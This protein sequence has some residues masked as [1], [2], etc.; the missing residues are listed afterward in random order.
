[1]A[2]VNYS[3]PKGSLFPSGT[4][5]VTSTAVDLS[6]N[7]ATCIFDVVLT[8][9]TELLPGLPSYQVISNT[10]PKNFLFYNITYSQNSHLMVRFT[11]YSKAMRALISLQ[12]VPSDQLSAG[13]LLPSFNLP[14]SYNH[15]L[16]TSGD[17]LL[18]SSP[19]ILPLLDWI[20]RLIIT[21]DTAGGFSDSVYYGTALEQRP[22]LFNS[23]APTSLFYSALSASEG[24]QQQISSPLSTSRSILMI[25]SVMTQK[26][27][28]LRLDLTPGMGEMVL[29][30]AIIAPSQGH[31]LICSSYLRI[32]PVCNLNTED[33]SLKIVSTNVSSVPYF[34]FPAVPVG[35]SLAA[36]YKKS[37]G[38]SIVF[39]IFVLLFQALYGDMA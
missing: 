32:D 10:R 16:L 13:S 26:I 1:L 30:F 34:V 27:R 2:S 23:V 6:G 5:R 36:Q 33:V 9:L 35:S 37:S 24:Y 25:D 11:A 14:S 15:S 22:I 31:L 29:Q 19:Y 28:Y 8:Q 21:V 4:T 17:I 38:V 7:I 20:P 18:F 39:S 12:H 3:P